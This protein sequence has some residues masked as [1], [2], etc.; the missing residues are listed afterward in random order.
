MPSDLS[1]NN[2]TRVEKVAYSDKWTAI[3]RVS[4]LVGAAA[5]L[6]ILPLTSWALLT[7]VQVDKTATLTAAQLEDF[8]ADAERSRQDVKERLASADTATKEKFDSLTAWIARLSMRIDNIPKR[9]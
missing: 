9:P 7:L 1:G 2:Q 8:K 4:S 3:G 6:I 5:G